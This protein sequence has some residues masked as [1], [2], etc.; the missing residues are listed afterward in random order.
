MT[1]QY[2]LIVIGAGPAGQ[3]GAVQAAKLKKS[4][5]IVEKEPH[6]G[7]ICLY[8]GTLPSKTL[9]ETVMFYQGFRKR[10]LRGVSCQLDKAMTLA[11]LMYQKDKVIEHERAIISDQLTRNDVRVIRGRA[12]FEDAH[13]IAVTDPEGGRTVLQAEYVLIAT[14]SRPHH[15]PCIPRVEA[16]IFD[17]DTILRITRIP[18]TLTV[19]GGG[20]IGCE[21]ACIF[22]VLGTKVTLVDHRKALMRF[23]DEE[24]T[25]ALSFHMR[26]MGTTF[27]LG[28]DVEAVEV[29]DAEQVCTRLKSGKIIYSEA[30][31]SAAG[32]AAATNDLNL[33]GIGVPEQESGHI[34]VNEYYQTAVP[35]VYAAGD[36]IGF[37]SLASASMDQGRLAVCHMFQYPASSFP[38]VL[39]YGVYTIPEIS[40]VGK[41]ERELTEQCVPYETGVARLREIAR[42]QIIGET[43]GLLKLIFHQHTRELLGVHVIGEGATELVHIGQAVIAHKGTIEYFVHSVFNYPTLAEAYKVAALNGLNKLR[44]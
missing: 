10:L 26:D 37:P 27:K 14:G 11:D 9:R 2:D 7:G 16:P 28:E 8:T 13:R 44:L 4:V 1:R 34:A 39:P 29:V 25:A 24:I 22:S 32:R 6:P 33:S 42:G 17:S 20:V 41:T 5:A 15:P 21:Y 40:V 31:L 19:L 12:A 35:H 38:N 36:V 30:L 18:R 23:M 43:D 3:K